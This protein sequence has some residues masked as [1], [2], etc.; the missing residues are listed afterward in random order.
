MENFLQNIEDAE[1]F[2]QTVKDALDNTAMQEIENIKKEMAQ[3][4]LQ[5]EE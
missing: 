3:D 5:G 2:K 4:F 1:A